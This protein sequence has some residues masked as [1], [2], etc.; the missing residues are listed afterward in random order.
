V[1]AGSAC[2]TLQLRVRLLQAH[3]ARQVGPQTRGTRLLHMQP[4]PRWVGGQQEAQRA[5]AGAPLHAVCV[6]KVG[7]LREGWQWQDSKAQANL[8]V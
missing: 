1:T 2:D 8:V 6:C 5:P 3:R 7:E 4:A